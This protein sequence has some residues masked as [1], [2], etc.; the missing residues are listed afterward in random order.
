M[1]R[2]RSCHSSGRSR[3]RTFTLSLSPSLQRSIHPT[4][5]STAKLEAAARQHNA[6]L[7]GEAES[8]SRSPTVTLIRSLVP[9]CLFNI[10]FCLY[11]FSL[12]S[13]A[14]LLIFI[15]VSVS[16]GED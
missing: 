2:N 5:I 12:I 14:L 1:R 13:C 8:G 3:T 15:A 9:S 11:L 10:S 6:R 16:F 7:N 4:L